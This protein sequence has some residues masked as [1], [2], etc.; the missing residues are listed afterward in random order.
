MQR[1]DVELGHPDGEEMQILLRGVVQPTQIVQRCGGEHEAGFF[2]RFA[3]RGVDRGFAGVDDYYARASAAPLN[4]IY[5]PGVAEICERTLRSA[6][7][8]NEAISRF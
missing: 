8:T 2:A 3:Q 4:S 7:A 5:S 1:A 6:S